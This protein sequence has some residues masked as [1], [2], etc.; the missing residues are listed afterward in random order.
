[1]T[2]TSGVLPLLVL[3]LLG[4]GTACS[5]GPTR[6]GAQPSWRRAP[7]VRVV[8]GASQQ[9]GAP[10]TFTVPSEPATAY[11]EPPPAAVPSAPL[12]DAVVAAVQR[13]AADR[14]AA[15]LQPDS[16]LYAA[17]EEL[18]AVVP[19]EG[20]IAYALVEFAMQH[21]GIVEPSPHLLVVWGALDAPDAI[22]EQLVPRVPELLGTGAVVRVGVGAARRNDR[23]EGVVVLAVQGSSVTTR[24]IPRA[25]PKGGRAAI[26]GRVLGGYRDP[27]LFVT[28]DDG[29]VTRLPSA[30]GGRAGEFKAEL[31]CG[32]RDGRQQVEIVAVDA[33]GS[34]VLA[35]FPVWCNQPVPRKIT[36]TQ[37]AGDD[38][39]AR[40][41]GDAEKALFALLNRDREAA[42]LPAL[43]WDERAAEVARA[44][45]REMK[46][47]GV[48]AHV[49]TTTGSAADRVRSAK[50]VTAAVLENIA[51]AYGV[52]EAHD[53]L[54]N[55]PGHR[56]NMLSTVATHV[57]IGVAFGEEISGQREMFVTQVFIRVP[58]PVDLA[59]AVMAV[60]QKLRYTRPVQDDPGLDSVAQK[61]A[62]ELARG[63]DT[64]DARAHAIMTL[65]KRASRFRR[66]GTVITAVADLDALTGEALLGDDKAIT[67]VGVG[68]AQGP[69]PDIGDTAIWVVLLVAEQR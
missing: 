21:H 11:N 26:E 58:P 23:G 8:V 59:R 35:N 18:A 9:P 3:A 54:M 33:T 49:S 63:L 51:R 4:L 56:A 50:I 7:G 65:D 47:T 46:A 40:T 6:V 2:R 60:R 14:G 61:L 37:P 12:T 67:H 66:V 68:V 64:K 28:R 57:G 38:V 29:S 15:A 48:V 52:S 69:H 34:T 20:V 19:E 41:E 55:S 16:R 1:M 36:V 31:A 32:G 62:D 17:A 22:V 30:P 39:V 53:G 13:V 43:V 44:H 27:E 24:P 42:G 25:L 5:A 45:S 10:F